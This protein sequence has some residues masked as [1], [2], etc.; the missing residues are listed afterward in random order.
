[1]RAT[2]TEK[3]FNQEEMAGEESDCFE[4]IV[5]LFYSA[6]YWKAMKSELKP[7]DVLTGGLS[8]VISAANVE[9]GIELEYDEDLTLGEK[10]YAFIQISY[11]ST[12]N[13]LPSF[14]YLFPTLSPEK[15]V[16]PLKKLS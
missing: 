3:I 11:S 6:G 15:L 4:E 10:M 5:H 8:W 1:M 7:F 14:I 16:K 12:I 9:I 13:E 2:V